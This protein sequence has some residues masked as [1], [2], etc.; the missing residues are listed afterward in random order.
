MNID[1][2]VRGTS[3]KLDLLSHLQAI[4]ASNIQTLTSGG[5]VAQKINFSQL[6]SVSAMED[7]SLTDSLTRY[8]TSISEED[9]SID[10]EIM[11]S[12][13]LKAMFEQSVEIFNRRTALYRMGISG[14][15]Q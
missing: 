3:A 10:Q 4:V 8:T 2:V 15:W 7:S 5:K 9:T 6:P 1:M 11:N 13:R 12:L 14:R